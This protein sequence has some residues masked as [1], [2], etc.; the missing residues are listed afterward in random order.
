MVYLI[1][2]KSFIDFLQGQEVSSLVT[3]HGIHGSIRCGK[4]ETR[5]SETAGWV[6]FTVFPLI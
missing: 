2:L 1:F 4:T 6:S 5:D 3:D